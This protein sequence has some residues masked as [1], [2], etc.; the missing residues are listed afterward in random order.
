MTRYA[1]YFPQFIKKGVQAELLDDKLLQF[2]LIKL[3]KPRSTHRATCS[4][5]T[6]ACRRLYDRY[7]LHIERAAHRTAAGVLHARGHGPGAWARSTAKRVPS[8]STT[9]SPASTS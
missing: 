5:I 7:F 4:S 2:D 1:E 6:S 8:S 3:G 9:C